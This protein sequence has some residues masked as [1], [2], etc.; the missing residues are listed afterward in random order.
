MAEKTIIAQFDIEGLDLLI[1]DTA[2]LVKNQQILRESSKKLDKTTEEGARKFTEQSAQIKTLGKNIT[3][4]TKLIQASTGVTKELTNALS[5]EVLTRN[6]AKA[7]N[8]ELAKLRDNINVKTTEGALAVADLNKKMDAN[9]VL[10]KDTSSSQGK[11][12]FEIGNY[13]EAVKGAFQ[14]TG[15]FNTILGTL[16]QSFTVLKAPLDIF[17]TGLTD[18]RSEY[19]DSKEAANGLTG[20]KKLL[21][22]GNGIAAA[23]F[24]V[25]KIAIA[26][27]GIGLLVVALGSLVTFLTQTQKGMDAVTSVTRP[28]QAVFQ[29][30]LGVVQDLGGDIFEFG[31]KAVSA[32]S[33]PKKVLQDLMDFME[34]N[35]MNRLNSFSVILEAL[36]NRDFKGVANGFLQLATGVE[37]VTDKVVDLGNKAIDG[38]KKVF[39]T[40]SEAVKEGNKA[41]KERDKLIKATVRAERDLII[42]RAEQLRVVKEQNKIAEDTTKTTQERQAA[43][44]KAINASNVILRA[45]QSLLDKKIE[46][47]NLENSL[48]ATTIE[49]EK[50]LNQLIAERTDKETQALELQ[51]TL[52]NKLNTIK[53]EAEGLELKRVQETINNANLE[54]EIY[55]LNNQTRLNSEKELT[56]KLVSEEINRLNTI[57]SEKDKILKAQRDNELISDLE[58]RLEK[59]KL[60]DEFKQERNAIVEEKRLQDEEIRKERELVDL[61]NRRVI[62]EGNLLIDLE[63]QAEAAEQKR[64][65]EL[66]D[67]ERTGADLDLINA[68][69]DGIEKQREE[70]LRQAQFDIGKNYL[71][72]ISSILGTESEIGKSVAIGGVIADKAAGVSKIVTNTQVANAKAIAAS[73]LTGGQPF[74]T[75]NTI[76]AGLG[77]GAS[78]ASASKAISEISSSGKKAERGITLK[79]KSHG[80]GGINL[81]DEQGRHVVE[82]QGDENVYVLN[83]NASSQI[84]AL[85]GLNVATGGIPLSTPVNFAMQGGLVNT[86][87]KQGVNLNDILEISQSQINTIRVVND[88][89]EAADVA[90]EA[91]LIENQANI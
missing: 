36:G 17:K 23:S 8:A 13:K 10:L 83:K 3:T 43:A 79:G 51:T 81:Y 29:A 20:A 48:N 89:V 87:I 72:S 56:N 22:K 63:L 7:S 46:T 62:S 55:L 61:E 2:K 42:L 67:A 18:I 25:L 88:P 47:K 12:K 65:Q 39:N 37:N 75:L 69:Y 6:Q 90:S 9:N 41:G 77:I 31:K 24:K 52:Q 27:T 74:V 57:Q 5:R 84:N 26:S 91:F 64:Q 28:L 15:G 35:V 44:E 53:R 85:S 38:T 59:A 73:P 32:L 40:V 71:A 45:E 19:K 33:S 1:D 86:S 14:E 34:K 54:L 21:A 68:K 58:F 30:L 16:Q 11:L 70:S 50:A 82:A 76:S 4:N 80:Q 78:V 49:D 60:E 66:L